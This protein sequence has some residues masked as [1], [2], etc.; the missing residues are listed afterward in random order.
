MSST[1]G[2]LTDE[3]RKLLRSA[4]HGRD[5]VP[6]EATSPKSGSGSGHGNKLASSAGS[7]SLT[8]DKRSNSGR[9]G[10][11]KKGGGGGKGTW[12]TLLDGD[13]DLHCDRHDPNYDSEEEPYKL[14]GAPVAQSLE[15]YR[16]KVVTIIEEYF[17]NDDVPETAANLRDVGSP[18]YHHYFIKKL[19]SMAM[20]RHD[21][22]KE[23]AS[24]LLSALYADIIEPEQIAKGFTKLLECVDDLS[25]DIP[26][27]SDILAL[28]LARAVVDDILPPA[29]L[30][31]TVKVL[32]EGCE[33]INVLQK[34]EKSYLLAPHHAE[35]VEKKWGGST[36]TTVEEVKR[37]ITDLLNEYAQ[38]G[39]REE[40]TRC[41]RELNVP[42]FHHEVVKKA[43]TLA[44]EK[45]SAESSIL[46]LLQECAEEGLITSSQMSKGFARL[47]DTVDDLAL[48]IPQAK[49]L[50][51]SLTAK[52]KKDGWLGSSLT[53][54][55]SSVEIAM[56]ADDDHRVFKQKAT[57]IIQEYFLSDD[58]AEVIRSLEDLAAPDYYAT[59][60]KRLITLALDRKYREKEQAS[61][62]LSALYAEVIPVGQIARAFVL[63]LESAEDT[64]LD[65]PD[66]ANELSL[67]LA[68]AVVDDILAPVYLDEI[69]EQL[70]EESLGHEI[71]HSTRAVLAATHAGERV[72]RC[73]GGGGTGQ[74]ID[75]T[76]DKIIKLLEEY[77]AGG[78]LSEACQCIRDLNMP[79]FHHEVVKKA[80]IMAMEKKDDRLLGLLQESASEGL[81]TTS[82]MV[83]GFSRVDD[84]LD[85]LSLDIPD[86]K[87]KFKLYVKEA[88]ANGWL[89][90]SFPEAKNEVPFT[91]GGEAA[92]AMVSSIH[93]KDKK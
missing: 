83:K 26:D 1:T 22:E 36:H 79:F 58:I 63:L 28:F 45:R 67:F 82:Q 7:G 32:P 20:D 23:M 4:S 18:M 88:K 78:E 41:I 72:L 34:T 29:F 52:A 91:N 75:D 90:S 74:P 5:T 89:K 2:F 93:L 39:D 53:R 76:K 56:P 15:E 35:V 50:L 65:I 69:D 54:T 47:A 60:L 37:K 55:A 73:W 66:A 44:M 46:S 62:L 40:A 86:A 77:A 25:L 9:Q 48:D 81:I 42:F 59:F 85:D 6:P 10:K 19:I 24:V 17:N 92:S 27:A 30:T 43:L 87:D 3:Q 68:R 57:T 11:P 70:D 33:G 31:K 14:V 38:S 80:L 84:A 21:R 8:K 64:S 12:G 51:Q 49:E 16:E 13:S 71:V 61:V